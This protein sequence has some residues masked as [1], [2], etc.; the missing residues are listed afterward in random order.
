MAE[1]T[2]TDTESGKSRGTS[3]DGPGNKLSNG[4]TYVRMTRAANMAEGAKDGNTIFQVTTIV[5]EG[6]SI[7]TLDV[8]GA[9]GRDNVLVLPGSA[10]D[11]KVDVAQSPQGLGG[12]Q[13]MGDITFTDKDGRKINTHNIKSVAYAS[14]SDSPASVVNDLST[15]KL[16]TTPT[17]QLHDTAYQAMPLMDQCKHQA[18]TSDEAGRAFPTQQQIRTREQLEAAQ[19]AA[20]AKASRSCPSR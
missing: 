4:D 1:I 14:D 18:L 10:T 12:R 17:Q 6:A 8:V 13:T 20:I 19:G 7:G 15:G 16:P 5:P 11:Y 3:E 9:P 2:F